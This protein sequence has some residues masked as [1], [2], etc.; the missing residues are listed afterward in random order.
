MRS[1]SE[2]TRA[3]VLLSGG[4]DSATVLAI[5]KERERDVVAVTFDYG[6]RHARELDSARRIAGRLGVE[7][8]IVMELDL[9]PFLES[10]LT[11]ISRELPE[12]DDPSAGGEVP[13]TYVPARNIVFL[14]IAAAFAESMGA[15]EVFIAA[16]A[17]DYSGYPDCTPEFLGAFQKTLEVGTKRGVEGSA[18]RIEAPLI[19]MSKGD[20]VREAIRLGVPVELTWSCYGGGERAC[21]RCDSC[22]LRLRGF[23]EA[24]VDDPL[25]YEES[26]R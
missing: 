5:A 11:R 7:K 16:N 23:R 14:S 8:H 18:V 15:D 1:L 21:G 12:R 25:E 9:G 20:I 6:Q 17:V 13:S 10:S 3:I 2:M 19:A 24:G 22:R 4:L 26:V